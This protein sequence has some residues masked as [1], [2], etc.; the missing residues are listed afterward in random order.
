MAR[1]RLR[2]GALATII[3]A[4]PVPAAAAISALPAITVMFSRW[5]ANSFFSNI[6]ENN[7][8]DRADMA[9]T[10]AD[11]QAASRADKSA[12]QRANGVIV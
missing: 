7:A 5:S 4:H 3:P 2:R 1:I 8:I 10:A 11:E 6:F 12:A 9:T